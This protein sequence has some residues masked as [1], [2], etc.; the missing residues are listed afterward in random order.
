MS[1]R[2]EKI[3]KIL[4]ARNLSFTRDSWMH[5][6]TSRGNLSCFETMRMEC[7]WFNSRSDEIKFNIVYSGSRCY[8]KCVLIDSNK[9]IRFIR[10]YLT[11]YYPM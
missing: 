4:D 10:I 11:E 6:E 7:I 8:S 3:Q 5:G 9:I 2:I 1:L